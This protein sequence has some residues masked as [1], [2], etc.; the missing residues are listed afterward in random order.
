MLKIWILDI[1]NL[2]EVF[3]SR[4]RAMGAGKAVPGAQRD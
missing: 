4:R 3:M 2:Y 1:W